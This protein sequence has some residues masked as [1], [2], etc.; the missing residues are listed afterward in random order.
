M[1]PGLALLGWLL[2]SLAAGAIGG[3]AS[4]NARDFY[5]ALA[6]PP[7]APPGW[8]FGPV[9]T[10]LYILMGIAAWLV[11][12]ERGWTGAR[13]ALSLFLVQLAANALWTWLFFAW[14]RGGL[15][16]AE[17]ILLAALIVATML[18]F[19]RVR[20]T[21]AA[22]LVPYLLWVLFATALTA[23]VWQRNRGLL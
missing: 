23:A 9:W 3:V 14:R 8:V 1:R 6:K 18:A 2:V 10:T 20:R 17:I 7:W 21:A 16:L 5:A 19:A 22:L 15:A 12:R 4:M 11:W 13:G